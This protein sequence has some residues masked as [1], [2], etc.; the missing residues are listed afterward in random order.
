[1]TADGA[2]DVDIFPQM[3]EELCEASAQ[4]SVPLNK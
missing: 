1:M 3:S 2:S 4:P